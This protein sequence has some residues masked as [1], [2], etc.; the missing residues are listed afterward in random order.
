MKNIKL[1]IRKEDP[2]QSPIF[3]GFESI[4]F[5]GLPH[6]LKFLLYT[7]IQDGSPQYQHQPKCQTRT[8][9]GQT[10][11]GTTEFQWQIDEA[12]AF[13]TSIV[14]ITVLRWQRLWIDHPIAVA[15]ISVDDILTHLLQ[16]PDTALHISLHSGYTVSITFKQTSLQSIIKQIQLS[17][18]VLQMLEKVERPFKELFNTTSTLSEFFSV[19]KPVIELLSI[20]HDKLQN[21]NLAS[22]QLAELIEMMN[23][24]LGLFDQVQYVLKKHWQLPSFHT[25]KL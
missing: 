13:T 4:V 18:A 14:S 6:Q 23:K 15:L 9:Y 3:L 7:K 11:G 10:V 17:H 5:G 1:V 21:H 20:L 19:V 12:F 22:G 2:G 25:M 24:I 16:N 8:T